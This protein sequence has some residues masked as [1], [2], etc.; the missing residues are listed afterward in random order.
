M[1]STTAR[2]H[3]IGWAVKHAKAGE[4]VTRRGWRT[5]G[6]AV[7]YR[8]PTEV[9]AQ[10]YLLLRTRSGRTW[11]MTFGQRD[12]LANDWQLAV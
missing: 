4:A 8:Q 2:P 1:P 7:T 11:P 9:R 6:Q 10:G 3:R 5:P 12:L